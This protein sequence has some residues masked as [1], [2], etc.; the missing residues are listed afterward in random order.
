MT[1][2]QG[3]VFRVSEVPLSM[4]YE[5]DGTIHVS[6][7]VPI[8]ANERLSRGG[9]EEQTRLVLSTIRDRLEAV[10][11]GLE[12][13]V[14]VTVLLAHATRDFSAMNAVYATFFPFDPRPARSTMGVELAVDVLIEIEMTAVRG[15]RSRSAA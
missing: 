14:K 2:G 1:D 15:H 4:L 7:H 12:D 13:V 11:S 9:I 3:E 8:D 10:G 6:G 5:A